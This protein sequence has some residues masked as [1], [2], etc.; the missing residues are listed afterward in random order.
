MQG[1]SR[2]ERVDC[3]TELGPE[4]DIVWEGMVLEITELKQAEVALRE[5][6]ARFRSLVENITGAI[7]RCLCDADWTMVFISDEIEAISGYPAEDFINNNCLS[8]A[9]IIHEE[10]TEMVDRQVSAAVESKQP[11]NLEYRIVRADGAVRWMSERGRP[12]YNVEGL[13]LWL[14]GAI[15]DIT[16][17]KQADLTLSLVT[18]AVA[19]ASAATS[20]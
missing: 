5:S 2:P 11:Y 7:Y 6:E 20:A 13:V 14:D 4:G 18:Q 12:T 19:S 15:F 3:P 10:D 17:R 9:S 8:F 1:I 16:D